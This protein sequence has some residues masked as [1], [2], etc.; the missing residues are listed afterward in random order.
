MMLTKPWR[1]INALGNFLELLNIF[2]KDIYKN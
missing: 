1:E 2:V